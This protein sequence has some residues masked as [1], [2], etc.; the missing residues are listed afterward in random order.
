MPVTHDAQIFPRLFATNASL[1]LAN[2]TWNSS[3]TFETS[4]HAIQQRNLSFPST[5]VC[6]WPPF[7]WITAT[8]SGPGVLNCSTANCSYARCWNASSQSMAIVARMPRHI[9]WPV[10]APSF[11]TLFRQRRDFG[12]TAAVISTLAVTAALAAATAAAVGSVQTAQTLNN[13]SAS[14]ATALDTQSA[15]NAHLKGGIM[16]LNQRVDLVQEQIDALWQLAQLGCEWR[17]TGLCITAVPFDNASAAANKSRQL[18]AML[19]GHWS[20]QFT[21]L[22]RQLQ[23]E[24][25]HINSTR[26]DLTVTNGLFPTFQSIVRGLRDWAGLGSLG[27]MGILG[28]GFV[29]WGFLRVRAQRRRDR[30]VVTQALAALEC[31]QS[32][33]IW[34][35]MLRSE[36]QDR[37]PSRT[38]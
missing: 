17:F 37:L 12:V 1:G 30:V 25:T 9:P 23:L 8:S 24:I 4:V 13:L 36:G 18:S 3:S 10:E 33:G 19:T 5:P 31:G 29:I 32:P 34:L 11:L 21:A 2:L 16:I 22:T 14:V 7:I 38:A 26:L 35:Q 6:L 15:V 20:S 28:A 27:F